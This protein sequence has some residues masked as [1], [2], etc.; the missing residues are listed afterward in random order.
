MGYKHTQ[1]PFGQ[2]VYRQQRQMSG[3]AK[4]IGMDPQVMNRDERRKMKKRLKRGQAEVLRQ[5]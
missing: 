5:Q 2:N 3:Q 4:L 1:Q